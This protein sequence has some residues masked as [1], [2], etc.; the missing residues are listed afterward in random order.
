MLGSLF[1]R[2]WNLNV[3]KNTVAHFRTSVLISSEKGKHK[4]SLVKI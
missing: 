3:P 2:M 4:F 1:S